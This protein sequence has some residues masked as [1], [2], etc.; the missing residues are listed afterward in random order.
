MKINVTKET[1]RIWERINGFKKHKRKKYT[2]KSLEEIQVYK[3]QHRERDTAHTK[4]HIE[5]I[6]TEVIYKG[7]ISIR[8][9]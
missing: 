7:N 1:H 5:E 9:G 6:G 2:E 4:T 3:G 8:E